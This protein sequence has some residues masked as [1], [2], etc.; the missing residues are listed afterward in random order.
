MSES[1]LIARKSNPEN[2][3]ESNRPPEVP[4]DGTKV[5]LEAEGN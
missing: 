2:V 4:G 5:R 3:H 1:N